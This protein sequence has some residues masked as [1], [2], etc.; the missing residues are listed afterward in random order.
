MKTSEVSRRFWIGV[1]SRDHALKGVAGGF[2]QLCH[3]KAA[4]LRR[5]AA[6]DGLVYYAPRERFGES[7]P[8]QRFVAIG[9]ISGSEI[10]P[11]DMGRGFV[12]F[13]RD[14]AYVRTSSEAPIRPLFWRRMLFRHPGGRS[15]G[16]SIGMAALGAAIPILSRS[17][18]AML[19]SALVFGFA[20]L[21]VP[22]AVT[23]MI[24]GFLPPASRGA[25]ITFFTVVFALGQIAGPAL[26]GAISD[27]SGNLSSSLT[28]SFLA[29][30]GGAIVSLFQKSP[31]SKEIRDCQAASKE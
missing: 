17:A 2:A 20:F 9:R 4:P 19:I 6:G 16:L 28:F 15:M 8:C 14:A 25:S 26:G 7:E 3:G 22:A 5:M 13:R 24:R 27:R 29:L 12:P 11:F 10:Y 30:A 18:P 21:N 23:A 31:L 1:A